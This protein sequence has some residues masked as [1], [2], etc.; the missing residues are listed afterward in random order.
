MLSSNCSSS[1]A[2]ILLKSQ[3]WDLQ[4]CYKQCLADHHSGDATTA[5]VV[6]E[7]TWPVPN[8]TTSFA[9]FTS[10]FSSNDFSEQFESV[11]TIENDDHGDDDKCK[12]PWSYLP[13]LTLP[14]LWHIAYWTSQSLTW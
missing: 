13:D 10:P 7:T 1:I 2:R 9:T 6:N 11:V 12:K 3:N 14:I 5:L 8:E 4:T